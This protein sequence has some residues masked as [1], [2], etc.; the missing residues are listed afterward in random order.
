ME[1]G[2][3]PEHVVPPEQEAE[4]TPELVR[5]PEESERPVPRR[6]LKEEPLTI[7]F[8]VEAELNEEQLVEDEKDRESLPLE[9]IVVVAEEP[10]KAQFADR[11]VEEAL[12]LRR[13]R[14]VVADCPPKG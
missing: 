4:M 5:E 2:F 13:I 9:S 8:V 3:V 10:K 12:P 14:E 11:P 7:K 1:R 6:L